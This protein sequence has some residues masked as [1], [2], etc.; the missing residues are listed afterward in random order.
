[1]SDEEQKP[2]DPFQ[3]LGRDL[4]REDFT[5]ERVRRIADAAIARG[6]IPLMSEEARRASLNLIRRG[7][8]DA[9]MP[10]CSAM[11]R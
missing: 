3:P 2:E 4:G 6:G 11:A 5:P 7:V 9:P 1:M 8:P 10:G